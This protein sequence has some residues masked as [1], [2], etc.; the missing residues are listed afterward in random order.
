MP[1]GSLRT[2]PATRR[3]LTAAAALAGAALA[4][5][6]LTMAGPA[7]HHAAAAGPP[8]SARQPAGAALAHHAGPATL[9]GLGAAP[10]LGAA[11]PTITTLTG[12][13]LTG[14][15]LTG[16]APR[17]GPRPGRLAAGR[18]TGGHSS[19]PRLATGWPYCWTTTVAAQ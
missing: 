8:A 4:I 17:R 9:R 6:P 13:T 7:A 14:A 11:G 5:T 10:A 3:R 15:T 19:R 16:A 2:G 18:G 1:T 12:A